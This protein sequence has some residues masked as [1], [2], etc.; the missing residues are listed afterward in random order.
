M[1]AGDGEQVV[2]QGVRDA[3]VVDVQ[4]AG[5]VERES[6]PRLRLRCLATRPSALLRHAEVASMSGGHSRRLGTPA[7]PR[8]EPRFEPRLFLALPPRPL[9]AVSACMPSDL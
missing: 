7:E 4:P 1:R 8:F 9:T 6:Q 2:L 5:R 3:E